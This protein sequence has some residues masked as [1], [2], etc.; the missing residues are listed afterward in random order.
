MS[1]DEMLDLIKRFRRAYGKGDRD[2]LVAATTE[3]F[4]W[5]MHTAN[6]V[7]TAPRAGC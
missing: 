4:E 6:R 2:G 3:D 5:H 1:D 7:P